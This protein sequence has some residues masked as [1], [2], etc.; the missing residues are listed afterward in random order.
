MTRHGR[1]LV[2]EDDPRARE[3]LA[4]LL[5]EEGYTVEAVEDGRLASRL[6]S[7]DGFDAAL[8]DVRMPGKDGLAVLRN[9]SGAARMG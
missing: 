3:S 5:A 6:L 4:A 1:I 8:L 2:A 9:S 7:E